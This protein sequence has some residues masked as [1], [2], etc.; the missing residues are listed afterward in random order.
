MAHLQPLDG[1]QRIDLRPQTTL[2]G[3]D[4]ACDV[5]VGQNRASSRHA[6]VLNWGGTYYAEDLHS[7]NG[8]FVNGRRIEQRTLL[9]PGDRLEVPGLAAIFHEGETGA[10]PAAAMPDVQTVPSHSPTIFSYLDVAAGPRPGVAPEAKLRAVLEMARALGTTLAQK[11]VL[12]TLLQS[13]FTIFPQADRGFILLRDPSS[14]QLVPVAAQQRGG[15]VG[16]PPVVSET[17]LKHALETGKAILSADIGQDSRFSQDSRFNASESL[18]LM[19]LS[20][21]LCVPMLSQGG[22]PLGVIQIDTRD[23]KSPFR[24]EDLDVLLCAS[25]QAARAIELA[26]LHEELRDLEAATRIQQSFLPERP[27]SCAGLQFF[28]HYAPARQVGGD[29]YDY[30]PLPGNRLAVTLGD[31]AGKGVSAALLMARLS[32]AAR[33]CLATAG[34]PS[35]AVRQLNRALARDFDNGRFVTFL[36]AVLDLASYHLTLVNA[37]HPPPLHLRQGEVEAVGAEAAG[38]P[39]AGIDR[40]YE[41]F[42]LRLRP[43][44]MLL[45]YTDGITE[46]RNP[47]GEFY[48]IARLRD[49]T[50]RGAT[51]P[52]AM[53]TAVLTAVRRFALGRPLS[54][55]QTLVCFG[56]NR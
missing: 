3:R 22:E 2:F 47:H 23:R 54:D 16:T 13:L 4:T 44:E 7:L 27:P 39:L 55:D 43:G 48:G 1:S 20:S 30:I 6:I 33:F 24:A 49:I 19:Q 5:V 42:P 32:A 9:H 35:E 15:H 40:P 41:E 37:G 38:L 29:Y 50:E 8:T 28:D 53:G 36:V 51:S 56:V 25:T 17:L 11:E 14:G 52:A 21:V 12:P 46:A 18:Q 26:N 10:G 31:V 45:G 34:S